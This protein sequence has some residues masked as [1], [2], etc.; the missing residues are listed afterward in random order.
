MFTG[1]AGW[2]SPLDWTI[3][4]GDRERYVMCASFWQRCETLC[5]M[6]QELLQCMSF[7]SDLAAT[8]NLDKTPFFKDTRDASQP[9]PRRRVVSITPRTP[10]SP[11]TPSKLHGSRTGDI[12]LP[13]P[14]TLARA[15]LSRRSSTSTFPST[16]Q[17]HRESPG[18]SLDPA[19][20]IPMDSVSLGL[21][22][23]Y[24]ENNNL[25]APWELLDSV[26]S[27]PAT[28]ARDQ[29]TPVPA[30]DGMEAGTPEP[31]PGANADNDAART[32]ASTPRSASSPCASA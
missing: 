19:D 31:M 23:V 6:K 17:R 13:A 12:Q 5:P 27:S 32:S 20:F 25:P 9:T 2:E 11:K 15:V 24:A 1:E 28:L 21:T 14:L 7:Y 26:T 10:R 18:L 3:I 22:H 29:A 4:E 16:P 30:V 8:W